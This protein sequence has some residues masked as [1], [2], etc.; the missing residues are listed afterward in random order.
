[1]ESKLLLLLRWLP[2]TSRRPQ[3]A[4][5]LLQQAPSPSAGSLLLASSRLKAGSPQ[6]WTR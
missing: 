6:H 5:A 2:L 3:Q 4:V 1:M